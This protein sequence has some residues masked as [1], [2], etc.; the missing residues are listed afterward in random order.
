M[1]EKQYRD[2]IA[3][4]KKQQAT[5]EAALAKA[6]AAAAKC[7]ADARRE[8]ARITPRTSASMARTH[9]R[10]AESAEKKAVTE[11]AKIARVST[12][13][14]CLARDLSSAETNLDREVRAAARRE[15]ENRNAAARRAEQEAKQRHARERRHAQEIARLSSPTVHYVHEVR[16][17]PAPKPE[18]LRVLYLTAD[19][20]RD[21]RTEVEV[22]NVQQAVRKATHR[23]L[24]QISYRP[25]A[26][27]EDLLDGLNELR[28][29]VVH[30]SGHGRSSTVFFDN[31]SVDTPGGREVA[32]DLLARALRATAD[33]PTLLVLN[34][35]D[36]LD[37]AEVLLDST[38]VIIAMASE[39]TDLAA[40]VFAARFYSAIASAQPVGAAVQQGSVA[41]DLAGLDEGWI[42]NVLARDDL[43]LDGLVLVQLPPE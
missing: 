36:T 16:T 20:G 29:H 35:C 22:R 1:S 8:V 28:P 9:Q 18:M 37:G 30:F 4:I 42:P 5:E 2:K 41:L 39:I 33:P 23:D 34:G 31:A 15:D 26:T 11:D 24:I 6:R 38:P 25:A 12:K 19:P 14:A 40:T 27:P 21:L 3:F 10:N 13:L 43:D 32:L 7:R 17:V